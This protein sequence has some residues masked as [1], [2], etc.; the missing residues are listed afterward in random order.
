MVLNRRRPGDIQRA[1]LTDYQKISNI[2]KSSDTYKKLSDEDKKYADNYFLF[3]I[4]GKLRKP[5]KALIPLD[6][7][8]SLDLVVKFRENAAVSEKNNYVFGTPHVLS[9]NYGYLKASSILAK[10]AVSCG[11]DKPHTIRATELRKHVATHCSERELSAFEVTEMARFLGH[12]KQVRQE[13][14]VQPII[15]RDVLK[16]SR[17]LESALGENAR[18]VETNEAID[19]F[20]EHENSGN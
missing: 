20:V 17:F 13:I 3:P 6:I 7:K 19:T 11:A 4:V 5:L 12:R 16:I 15:Q 18:T 1:E 10:Y 2:D 14:Y 8:E 9:G